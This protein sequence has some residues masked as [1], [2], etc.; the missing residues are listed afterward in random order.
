M[1]STVL[2]LL[3]ACALPATAHAFEAVKDK[4][5][6]LALLEGKELRNGLMGITLTVAADGTINGN[7]VR[8]PVT[9]TWA[10][11]DGFFCREMDWS[12]Y[13]IDYNCQ[14]VEVRGDEV[15]FT[16]D[17]GAGDSATFTLRAP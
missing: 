6:F 1:K 17:Q 12:G 3:A 10:W 9:G 15:R 11:Q 7:A 5:A 8:W 14:L 2:A 16:V 4:D 13:P